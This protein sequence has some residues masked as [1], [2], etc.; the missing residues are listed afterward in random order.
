MVRMVVGTLLTRS[1]ITF[2]FLNYVQPNIIFLWRTKDSAGKNGGNC[3][4]GSQKGAMINALGRRRTPQDQ[5][6]SDPAYITRGRI[7]VRMVVDALPDISAQS[8]PVLTIIRNPKTGTTGMWANTQARMMVI[9]IWG[10]RTVRRLLSAP[11]TDLRGL[12]LN[13][14]VQITSV[15]LHLR[16]LFIK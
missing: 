13:E 14:L 3:N 8:R 10:T 12:Q 15:S 5:P 1:G 6:L 9:T 4:L 11:R 7:T 2:L 16:D